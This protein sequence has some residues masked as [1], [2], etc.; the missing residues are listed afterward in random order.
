MFVGQQDLCKSKYQ[1]VNSIYQEMQETPVK[2]ESTQF[3][4]EYTSSD[5]QCAMP[6]YNLRSLY[7]DYAR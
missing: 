7:Y 3:D 2:D 6:A 1:W 4:E 5:E